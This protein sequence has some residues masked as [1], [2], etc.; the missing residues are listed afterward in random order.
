MTTTTAHVQLNRAYVQ[1]KVI[2]ANLEHLGVVLSDTDGAPC[3]ELASLTDGFRRYVRRL[4]DACIAADA[5]SSARAP[6]QASRAPA[7][8]RA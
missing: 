3:D 4:S 8:N 7:G 5:P 1:G 6:F 2:Q